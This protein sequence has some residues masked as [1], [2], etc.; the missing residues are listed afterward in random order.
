[1]AGGLGR[2]LAAVLCCALAVSPGRGLAPTRPPTRRRPAPSPLRSKASLPEPSPE[3]SWI[4]DIFEELSAG[5]VAELP[6]MFV[7]KDDH[8]TFDFDRWEQHRSTDRY[9]RLLIGLVAGVTTRRIFTF[10]AA[11]VGFSAFVQIYD[12]MAADM[13]I[14]PELQLPLTPFE[15]T[16]PVLGLLLVFRTNSAYDR[17]N[18]GSDATWR[19]TS[20]CRSVIRQLVAYIDADEVSVEER[21]SCLQLCDAVVTLHEY[22]MLEYLREDGGVLREQLGLGQVETSA[23]RLDRALDLPPR[24]NGLPPTPWVAMTAL[25]KSIA[26]ELPLDVNERLAIDSQFSEVTSA[27]SACEKVLRTPIPLGYTRYTVRFLFLWLFLLPFALVRKFSE[28][29]IG[30]WWEDKPQPVLVIAM[31]FISI[32]FLSIEDIGVQIE[33]PFAILPLQKHHSWLWRDAEQ[34]KDLLKFRPPRSVPSA[35]PRAAEGARNEEH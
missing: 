12:N 2:A 9:G 1:M 34:M 25:Q 32:I 20:R 18:V 19:I 17:F 35:E 10:V 28:F 26:R 5:R 33:E 7:N 31:L 23:S 8:V 16:A 22:L 11:L 27:L 13:Q 3:K 6:V 15:L 24:A 4:A 14:L 30:T 29:G 21:H